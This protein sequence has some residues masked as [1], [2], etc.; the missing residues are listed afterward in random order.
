M[1]TTV[2]SEHRSP[3]KATASSFHRAH[4]VHSCR[5][6][7][8]PSISKSQ[9]LQRGRERERLADLLP[10]VCAPSPFRVCLREDGEG[11]FLPGPLGLG[12]E[13]VALSAMLQY[14]IGRDR[15]EVSGPLCSAS[16]GAQAQSL[17]PGSLASAGDLGDL[18]WSL[19]RA[20]GGP[21][22]ET[23]LSC[24]PTQRPTGS[25]WSQ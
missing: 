22:A 17:L 2:H 7:P 5:N 12:E 10:S 4:C 23:S 21:R 14:Q 18:P 6:S 20:T 3:T 16:P 9:S 24:S 8:I 19:V 13:E 15:G 25:P 1:A 11:M